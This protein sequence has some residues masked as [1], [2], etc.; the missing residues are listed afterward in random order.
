MIKDYLKKKMEFVDGLNKTISNNIPGVANISYV[1]FEHINKGWTE[2]YLVF[3]YKGGC[4][5]A[6]NCS[7]NSDL[8]NLEEVAK[9]CQSSQYYPVD[10][11]RFNEMRKDTNWY[12]WDYVNTQI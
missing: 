4:V 7:A 6:R 12:T 11:E 10:T 2:E 3:D 9:M 1:V 8:A 5:Q